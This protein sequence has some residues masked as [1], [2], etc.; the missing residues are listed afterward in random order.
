MEFSFESVD[1]LNVK[2]CSLATVGRKNGASLGT[3]GGSLGLFRF[4]EK[5]K[6]QL[7]SSS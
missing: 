5:N 7:T 3:L 1:V 2:P 4:F 6:N